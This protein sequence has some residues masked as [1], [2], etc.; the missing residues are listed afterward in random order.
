LISCLIYN[1]LVLVSLRRA[2]RQAGQTFW[3]NQPVVLARLRN[4]TLLFC[5]LPLLI[6]VI[7]PQYQE[8]MGDYLIACYLTAVIY[9]TS[10]LVMS[11]SNF[12]HDSLTDQLTPVG[13]PGRN[14]PGSPAL[15]DSGSD[16]SPEEPRKKYEKSSLSEEVE[17][18]VLRKLDHLL[19]TEKP[20]LQSDMSLPKLAARLGTSPHHLSQLLNDRLGQ[21]FFDWLATYRIAEAQR[22]LHSPDTAYLKIDKIAERVGY[23]SPSAFHTAFKRITNQT[24]AQFRDAAQTERN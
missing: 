3:G 15:T 23:N 14:V 20:Y 4:Q 24:P 6:L 17:A 12:F 19:L 7:K 5:L 21:R 8:D 13:D 11:G 9:V 22:L 16:G 1:I 18:A 2:F 10:Y